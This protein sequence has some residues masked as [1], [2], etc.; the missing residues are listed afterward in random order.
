MTCII[1]NAEFQTFDSEH[2]EIKF[3]RRMND[4]QIAIFRL[5]KVKSGLAE[6]WGFIKNISSSGMMIE[7]HPSFEL[8][9]TA[10]IT[11]TDDVELTG[12]LRWRKGALAGIQFCDAINVAA[13]LANL[14]IHKKG[15][16]ARLPRVYMKQPIRL[17]NGSNL[18]D[19]EICDISPA[20]ICIKTQHLFDAGSKLTLLVPEL[21]DIT[22]RVRW[23]KNSR[24]GISFSE[25]ISIPNLMIWLSAYFAKSKIAHNDKVKSMPSTPSLEY[26][27]VGFDDLGNATSI[28]SRQSA[29]EALNDFKTASKQFRKVSVTNSDGVEMF[30]TVLMQNAFRER[31]EVSNNFLIDP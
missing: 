2:E 14:M 29:I 13:L 21:G 8:D 23:Q 17:R 28:S 16:S 24:A 31:V 10:S 6:G 5:A 27:V 11:L 22:G 26:H 3:D 19:A 18:M 30:S 9:R 4:R 1:E 15:Q 12:N 7:I 20:G 25:R